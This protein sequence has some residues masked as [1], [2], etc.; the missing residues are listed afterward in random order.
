MAESGS[1]RTW[2]AAPPVRQRRPAHMPAAA[3]IVGSIL[4]VVAF[5]VQGLFWLDAHSPIADPV[6]ALEAGSGDQ[7]R[8]MPTA[9][10]AAYGSSRDR[11]SATR[12]APR[13][14]LVEDDRSRV[15]PARC[16]A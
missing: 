1:V 14:D 10:T 4:F 16:A 8:N 15:R 5:I 9:G 3:G 6:S 7:S 11:N 2:T 13:D 12:S